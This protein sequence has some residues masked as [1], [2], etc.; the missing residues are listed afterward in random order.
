[1]QLPFFFENSGL[2]SSSGK[3]DACTKKMLSA[4]GGSF[5]LQWKVH[6][7]HDDEDEGKRREKMDPKS[8]NHSTE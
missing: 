4:A 3:G 6:G 5:A 8:R 7:N 2:S 1:L